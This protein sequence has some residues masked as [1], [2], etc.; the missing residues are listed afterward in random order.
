[1]TPFA[2]YHQYVVT[3][4]YL[5]SWEYRVVFGATPGDFNE[6]MPGLGTFTGFSPDELD[7][8]GKA[9][10]AQLL[11]RRG[12]LVYGESAAGIELVI[13]LASIPA[14]L[15]G[16]VAAGKAVKFVIEKI[17]SRRKWT[18]AITDSNTMAAAVAAASVNTEL[19]DKLTGARLVSVRNL[20]GGDRL[21]TALSGAPT[22]DTFGQL[23]L[24]RLWTATPSSS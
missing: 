4:T 8:L 18:V 21:G 2:P 16:L 10:S 14:N 9:T 24:S 23:P 11:I 15:I 12:S 13:T 20:F 7:E 3:V 22:Q 1:M 5:Q 19:L 6:D 17:Q